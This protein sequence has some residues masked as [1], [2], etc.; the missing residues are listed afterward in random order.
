MA[1]DSNRNSDRILR[2]Y[3][4]IRMSSQL[5]RLFSKTPPSIKARISRAA[6]VQ[7]V[8]LGSV[9][10][11]V[12]PLFGKGVR[13]GSVSGHIFTFDTTKTENLCG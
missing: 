2:K 7:E 9:L 8:V 3:W 1:E 12:Y 4:S 13:H 10:D 5:R 6:I 11:S